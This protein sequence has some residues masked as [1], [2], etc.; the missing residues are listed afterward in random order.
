MPCSDGRDFDHLDEVLK[1]NKRLAK[2]ILYAT[3]ML[4]TEIDI[5]S[6]LILVEIMENGYLDDSSQSPKLCDELTNLLCKICSHMDEDQEDKIIYNSRVKTSR[7]L[8]DW[9]DEHKELDK[10]RGNV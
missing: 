4:E 3:Q 1:K 10:E 6:K 7:A 5:S 9:W 8:A 2:L